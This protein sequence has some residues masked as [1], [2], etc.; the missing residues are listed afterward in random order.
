M[1]PQAAVGLM[2]EEVPAQPGHQFIVLAQVIGVSPDDHAVQVLFTTM[3]SV[4]NSTNVSPLKVKVLQR[5]AGTHGAILELPQVGEWGLVCFPNGSDQMAVWLGSVNRDL[6]NLAWD[7]IGAKARLDQHESGVYSLI[8]D[9]GNVDSVF[10]D[11]T[12]LRIGSGTVKADRLHHER[13]GQV[14]RTVPFD[15]PTGN[16]VTIHLS[17]SS[18][19]QVTIQPDGSVNVI[20]QT[21]VTVQAGGTMTVQGGAPSQTVI[22]GPSQSQFVVLLQGLANLIAWAATHVHTGVQGGPDDSGP[23]L[24][25][26]TPPVSG[27]DFTA[28]TVAS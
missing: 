2:Y 11:G 25:P 1:H 10:P 28:N 20:G 19:T 7:G 21:D 12:Y 17:H 22:G 9:A 26:P 15:N 4:L 16:P 24:A 13:Q 27:T 23:P 18:G 5:R 8:D 14:R 6:S 3:A